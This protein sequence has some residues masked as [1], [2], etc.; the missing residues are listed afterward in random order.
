MF[1]S[2]DAGTVRLAEELGVKAWAGPVLAVWALGSLVGGLAYGSMVWHGS[3]ASRLLWGVSFTGIGA[4]TFALAPSLTVLAALMFLTGMVIAP[5]MAVGDGVVHAL[6]PRARVTEGMAWTRVGMDGG[7]ALGAALAGMLIERH[8]SGG[9]FAVTTV[10]GLTGL[11]L[12]A[13]SWNYLR[14]KRA[15]E[16]EVS[17]DGSDET[18]GA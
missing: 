7:V 8:G 17:R 2:V 5:T 12:V 11:V 16:E 4:S 9:G 14:R 3:L 18:M 1:A 6:V 15:Y 13:A 10:A